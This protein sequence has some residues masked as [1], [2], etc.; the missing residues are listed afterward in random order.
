MLELEAMPTYCNQRA[1]TGQTASLAPGAKPEQVPSGRPQL[2][3]I[4]WN[5]PA[6]NLTSACAS[7]W[8]WATAKLKLQLDGLIWKV[9]PGQESLNN[10]GSMNESNLDSI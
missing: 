1:A 6:Q 2:F 9:T 7:S 8:Q 4:F 3:E 10:A 5:L